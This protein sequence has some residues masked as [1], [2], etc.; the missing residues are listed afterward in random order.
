MEDTT[1]ITAVTQFLRILQKSAI[2]DSGPRHLHVRHV[3]AWADIPRHE[4]LA[5]YVKFQHLTL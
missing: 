2:K 1:V 4:R 5:G 3:I